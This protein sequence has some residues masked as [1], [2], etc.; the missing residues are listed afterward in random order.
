MILNYTWSGREKLNMYL[1][2]IITQRRKRE[3]YSYMGR[4]EICHEKEI[5]TKSL[6][7][8]LEQKIVKFNTRFYEC[9]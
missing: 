1:I 4:Y 9:E 3:T 2:V 8:R 7:K 5:C 6:P